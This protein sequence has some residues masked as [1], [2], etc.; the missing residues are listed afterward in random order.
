MK[1]GEED[2]THLENGREVIHHKGEHKYD[3][4]GNPRYQVQ[5]NKE[6]YDREI[7]H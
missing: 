5:S 3:E 7:L 6:L 4:N 2:G 1:K